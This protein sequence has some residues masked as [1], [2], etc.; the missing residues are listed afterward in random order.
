MHVCILTHARTRTHARRLW[1]EHASR[2]RTRVIQD[3]ADPEWN[4]SFMLPIRLED[5][6]SLRMVLWD[7]DDI[8]SNDRIGECVRA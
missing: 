6:Q 7:W 1:V 4:D 3:N 5:A 2:R 8:M